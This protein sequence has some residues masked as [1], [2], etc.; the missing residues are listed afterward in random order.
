MATRIPL[1]WIVL[2]V[3]LGVF[4]FFGYHIL[5][6]SSPSDM[7]PINKVVTMI[8]HP[9]IAKA[10]PQM[11]YDEQEQEHEPPHLSIHEESGQTYEQGA[12]VVPKQKPIPNKMPAVPAQTEGDLR[13]TQPHMATPPATQYDTPEAIDPL[14]RTVYMGAEFGSNLRHPEQMIESRP[15]AGMGGVVASG[16]GS[17]H[18]GPGGNRATGYAPEMAQNGGEFM[19]GINAFDMSDYGAGYSM[20]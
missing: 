16:L 8:Q 1:S 12:P 3:L 20:F 18:S 9:E 10:L 7:A 2:L 11:G 14:N 15:S 13:A 17:E 4:A 5:Q 6:A 19:Q